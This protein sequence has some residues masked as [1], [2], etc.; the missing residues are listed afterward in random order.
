MGAE[1]AREEPDDPTAYERLGERY[2]EMQRFA[3]AI[4]AYE[5]TVQL[6][7]RNSK[8]AF[9]LAQLYVQSGTPMKATELLRNVLRTTTER[10]RD[11]PRRATRRSISRR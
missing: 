2:V 9:A 8:A 6:D 11:Q 7:P 3:D 5:K 1:G 10:R 4:A